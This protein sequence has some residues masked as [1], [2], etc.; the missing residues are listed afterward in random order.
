LFGQQFKISREEV[1][2]GTE[3]YE[4]F[5]MIAKASGIV[6]PQRLTVE[7]QFAPE[8]VDGNPLVG[9]GM[10]PGGEGAKLLRG[11]DSGEERFVAVELNTPSKRIGDRS[12]R[13]DA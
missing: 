10:D 9:R 7:F 11:I 2:S 5:P 3:I 6:D 13:N 1:P 4:S 8:A 12:R